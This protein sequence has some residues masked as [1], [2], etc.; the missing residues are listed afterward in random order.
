MICKY[1]A[2]YILFQHNCIVSCHIQ[3]HTVTFPLW[4]Q[5]VFITY[6]M[7]T[8]EYTLNIHVILTRVNIMITL[9]TLCHQLINIGQK[10][11]EL[12]YYV[13]CAS[14]YST[15]NV[16]WIHKEGTMP[17]LCTTEKRGSLQMKWNG[18]SMKGKADSL[19]D[20]VLS[21]PLHPNPVIAS[22]LYTAYWAQYLTLRGSVK[23]KK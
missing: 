16:V 10:R 19:S 2:K 13:Y 23:V 6:N 4:T 14:L 9:Q 5:L 17:F 12:Q 15:W 11:D 20:K 1:H 3:W 18:F 22:Q 21:F 7:E 8:N